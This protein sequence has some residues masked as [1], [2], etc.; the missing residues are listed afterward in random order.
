[1]AVAPIAGTSCAWTGPGC[2]FDK[3]EDGFWLPA[4]AAMPCDSC[5]T[6]WSESDRQRAVRAGE[7][8][9]DDPDHTNR[10][11]HIPGTAHLWRSLRA[12]VEEGAAADRGARIDNTWENYQLWYNERLGERWTNEM[13]GL[14]ARRMQRTT[15]SLGA[16]GKNDLGELDRRAVLVTAGRRRARPRPPPRVRRVGHRAEDGTGALVG[17]PV[18][19]HRRRPRGRY[20]GPGD[21]ARVFQGDRRERVATPGIPG[22][23]DR[24]APGAGRRRL[25]AGHRA[26]P[27][28]RAVRARGPHHRHGPGAALRRSHPAV[29]GQEPGNGQ[30]LD[31][32]IGRHEPPAA[33]QA[34]AVPGARVA[35]HVHDQGRDLRGAVA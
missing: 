18:P 29:A 16:R 24:R 7:Y 14:S 26:P 32:P 21:L 34:P 25:S 19:H 6:V 20:R 22:P 13:H 9:H 10:S 35:A 30:S 3:D 31:R 15:Y 17:A 1:M 11:F 33:G 27:V 8:V 4:T 28:D 12:I 23:R 2:K 5:G